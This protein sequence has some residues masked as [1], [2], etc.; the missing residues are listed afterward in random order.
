MILFNLIFLADHWVEDLQQE[1]ETF[2]FI[3]RLFDN[4]QRQIILFFPIL[5][6]QPPRSVSIIWGNQSGLSLS[7][8]R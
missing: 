1:V 4:R 2:L 3:A 7:G 8:I 6:E 5:W